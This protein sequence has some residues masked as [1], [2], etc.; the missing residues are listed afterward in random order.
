MTAL[1]FSVCCVRLQKQRDWVAW[2]LRSSTRIANWVELQKGKNC[3]V[4]QTIQL[5]TINTW[6]FPCERMMGLSTFR[7]SWRHF[8]QITQY[9]K[10]ERLDPY[11]TTILLNLWPIQTR[12]LEF[13]FSETIFLS[14][15]M[16]YMLSDELHDAWLFQS[17][18]WQVSEENSD[19]NRQHW[20]T[21]AAISSSYDSQLDHKTLCGRFDNTWKCR[22]DFMHEYLYSDN[23]FLQA[24]ILLLL[25]T[26]GIWDH[27]LGDELRSK[28]APP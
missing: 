7:P 17:M 15:F 23:F 27:W 3:P 4:R 21:N 13:N 18:K 22:R 14:N 8:K 24:R 11:H 16:D 26:L 9:K 28:F 2:V 10:K 12:I 1:K 5:W 25:L 6:T 19:F 20:I